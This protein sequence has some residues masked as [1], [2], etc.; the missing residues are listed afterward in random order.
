MEA[1][2]SEVWR[3]HGVTGSEPGFM[4]HDNGV[5]SLQLEDDDGNPHV[6]FE[7]DVSN[8]SDV[9][10]P[11]VQMSGGCSFVVHDEKYRISFVRPQN[12]RAPH[13]GGAIAGVASISGGRKAGKAWKSLLV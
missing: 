4:T 5:V 13:A 3:L 2:V 12:T 6:I 10:F 1:T 9:K 7:T 11:V 8:V